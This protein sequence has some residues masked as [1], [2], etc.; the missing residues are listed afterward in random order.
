MEEVLELADERATR[1]LGAKLVRRAKIGDAILLFGPLG[2]GKTTLVRGALEE[3]GW[4]GSVRSPTYNLITEYGSSPPVLHADL[5][6]LGSGNDDMGLLESMPD[7]ISFIEWAERLPFL[8][9][10][11]AFQVTIEFHGSGRRATVS[12]YSQ[13]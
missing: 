6:R 8:A 7:R 12:P 13:A 4:I 2:V 9:E 5:Y 10:R 3:L 1:S 11:A